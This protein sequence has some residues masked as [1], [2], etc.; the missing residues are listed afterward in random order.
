MKYFVAFVL[1][2]IVSGDFLCSLSLCKDDEEFQCQIFDEDSV[3]FS[4]FCKKYAGKLSENCSYDKNLEDSSEVIHLEIGGCD[5]DTVLQ[6]IDRLINV[7]TLD[8][9]YSS[10]KSLDSLNFFHNKLNTMNVSHNDLTEYPWKKYVYFFARFPELIE[11]D[12]SYNEVHGIHTFVNRSIIKLKRFHL[13][14]NGIAFI[15]SNAFENFTELEYLDLSYNKIDQITPN[16]FT[17]LNHLAVLHLENNPIDFFI[18]DGLLNMKSLSAHIPWDRIQYFDT[19]CDE[20]PLWSTSSSEWVPTQFVVANF[21]RKGGF[22]NI[23]DNQYKLDCSD[24][25]FENIRTFKA[26]T[27]KYINILEL[28]QCFGS[29]LIEMDLSGNYIGKLKSTTFERFVNL[30]EL[31]LKGAQLV[32]FDFQMIQQQKQLIT[33]DISDN[34]LMNVEN[35]ELTGNL[36]FLSVFKASGNRLKSEMIQRLPSTIKHLDMSGSNLG[37]LTQKIFHRLKRLEEL[38]LRNINFAISTTDPFAQLDNLYL[39]DVSYN[40]LHEVDLAIFQSTL[41]KLREFRAIE[42]NFLNIAEVM[43]FFGHNLWTLDLSGNIV[44]DVGLESPL[45]NL[46]LYS[47]YLNAASISRFDFNV[48]RKSNDLAI[49]ELSDNA[50][51]TIDLEPLS[52]YLLDLNLENNDLIDIKNFTPHQFPKLRNLIITQ[53]RLPCDSLRQINTEWQDKVRDFQIWQQRHIEDC[54]SKDVN[55]TGEFGTVET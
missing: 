2:S 6:A 49:L 27:N 10:Y 51:E 13:S 28:L 3:K 47:L 4:Y 22:F 31:S 26:G 42:C 12:L 33:L 44:G 25:S 48:L 14:H 29:S 35:V 38:I 32:F 53:N 46:R 45:R 5:N 34:K 16:L 30:E 55:A 40:N 50:L 37:R 39:L 17:N 11:L 54:Q 15:Q 7:H 20:F 36:R 23:V 24:W 21:M 43:Q 9:S 41:R 1:C 52:S 8:V 19:N 18:C